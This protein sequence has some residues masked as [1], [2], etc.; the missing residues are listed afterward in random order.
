MPIK[1]NGTDVVH[2]PPGGFYTYVPVDLP[3]ATTVLAAEGFTAQ[4]GEKALRERIKA[5]EQANSGSVVAASIGSEADM[6]TG[7]SSG[8]DME[9]HVKVTNKCNGK[10]R[11]R[12]KGAACHGRA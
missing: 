9:A 10:Y 12:S 1:E 4:I 7:G 2:K 8:A 3:H 11:I 6:D 5:K